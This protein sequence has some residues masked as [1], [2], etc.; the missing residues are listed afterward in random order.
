[1]EGESYLLNVSGLR[2][3]SKQFFYCLSFHLFYATVSWLP[4]HN[5]L[6]WVFRLQRQL[7]SHL[8]VTRVLSGG[9][10]NCRSAKIRHSK[11]AN[12]MTLVFVGSF[13]HFSMVMIESCL[14]DKYLSG[15]NHQSQIKGDCYLTSY[16]RSDRLSWHVYH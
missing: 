4:V 11:F 8:S 15:Y 6:V 1:M 5:S 13:L 2:Q 14:F 7:F 16:P 10:W 3:K 9:Q 12:L